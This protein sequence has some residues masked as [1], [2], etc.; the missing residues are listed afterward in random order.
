MFT[1]LTPNISNT[2]NRFQNLD[3]VPSRLRTLD[4]MV[5]APDEE[6]VSQTLQ[7]PTSVFECKLNRPLFV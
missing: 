7:E 1:L 3:Y 4:Q 5:V 2:L 6:F